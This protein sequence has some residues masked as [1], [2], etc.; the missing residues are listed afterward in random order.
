MIYYL[1]TNE[2]IYWVDLLN[3]LKLIF[4]IE[5]DPLTNIVNDWVSDR[6]NKNNLSKYFKLKKPLIPSLSNVITDLINN[7][8]GIQTLTQS[9]LTINYLGFPYNEYSAQTNNIINNNTNK[10][11]LI[12]FNQN[13]NNI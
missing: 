9:N 8:V 5:E 6:S 4:S 3:E 1:D 11:R 12:N 7:N 13:G 10:I 2:I